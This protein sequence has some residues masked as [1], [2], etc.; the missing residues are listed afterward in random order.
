MRKQCGDRLFS[1]LR[2]ICFP[3]KELKENLKKFHRQVFIVSYLLKMIFSSSYKNALLLKL[4]LI[5]TLIQFN[6]FKLLLHEFRCFRHLK[7]FDGHWGAAI[8]NLFGI[9]S[10]SWIYNCMFSQI[11]PI[12]T[13]TYASTFYYL[14]KRLFQRFIFLKPIMFSDVTNCLHQ[15]NKSIEIKAKK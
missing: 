7:S 1:N 6:G 9:V 5:K 15:R 3:I 8:I 2:F 13:Y 12:R 11:L 14:H 10:I 4:N